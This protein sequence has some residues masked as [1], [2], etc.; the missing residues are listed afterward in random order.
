M[1]FVILLLQ[2]KELFEVSVVVSR[3]CCVAEWGNGG[4]GYGG[5]LLY[6]I[7]ITLTTLMILRTLTTLITPFASHLCSSHFA[8]L[9]VT[10]A[11]WSFVHTIANSIVISSLKSTRDS[12]KPLKVGR[13]GSGS[14]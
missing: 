2:L 6:T 10:Y 4:V 7:L 13:G 11:F 5:L 14:G 9:S 8:N 1:A 3:S 12:V